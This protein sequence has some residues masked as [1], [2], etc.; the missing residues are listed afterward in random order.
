M[1][2]APSTRTKYLHLAHEARTVSGRVKLTAPTSPHPPPLSPCCPSPGYFEGTIDYRDDNPNSKGGFAAVRSKHDN[3][4]Y[5][6]TAF[7]AL[8]MRVKTDGRHYILNVKCA[9]LHPETLWQ[10]KIVTEPFRWT[11]LA[12]PFEDL[13]MTRRGV[14]EYNQVRRCV[15]PCGSGVRLG[16]GVRARGWAVRGLY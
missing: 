12:V 6:F 8:E 16:V 10:A 3:K 2:S 15:A 1:R 4:A 11:T 5:D 13:M 14:I 9:R 7:S